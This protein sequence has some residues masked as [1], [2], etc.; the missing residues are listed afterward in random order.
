MVVVDSPPRPDSVALLRHTEPDVLLLAADDEPHQRRDPTRPPFE[1]SMAIVIL[2]N[3]TGGL[4]RRAARAP[5]ITG[6]LL[7]P[8]RPEQV[9]ATLDI[10]VARFREL[11]RFRR[12]LKD[13][14]VVEE[15]KRL[16]MAQ[17][18]LSEPAAF[19]LLRKRAMDGRVSIGEVARRV[20]ENA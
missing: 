17:Q 8:L 15:A 16:L 6:V 4:P 19:G 12:A 3:A 9:G 10:A 13:R 20:I 5:G 14:P 2:A 1:M 7:R 11:R 18:G